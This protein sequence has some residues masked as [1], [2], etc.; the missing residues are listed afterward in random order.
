MMPL[1]HCAQHAMTASALNVGGTSV[2][3]RGFD[4]VDYFATVA[5]EKITWMFGLPMMYRTMLDHPEAANYDLSS[6]RYCLYAMAPMDE[7]TLRRAIDRFGA[8]F[9][10]GTGQTEMYPG[11]MFFKPE[12]QL[13]RFGPYWGISS[14]I[15]DTAIMDDDGNLLPPGQAG[16]IVHRGPTVMEGYWKNEEATEQARKFGWHHTGDLGVIDPDGQLIFVDRK[17]DMIKTGGEN[18]PSIKV[19]SVILN[20]PRIANAA[21]VGL[22]HARWGEAV[23]AFVAAK[24]ETVI[25]EEEIIDHCKQQLA[26]F[27]VPKAVVILDQFPLTATGKIQ[28]NVL[29]QMYSEHYLHTQGNL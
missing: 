25:T 20:E 23:T 5:R 7:G 22:P 15:V 9:G 19:E 3:L 17:K 11:T 8:R 27:E 4:P 1:F 28:K 29:R 13:R 18:V 12:E 10:L 16:E 14:L 26:G 24:P 2:V 21:V 6:L